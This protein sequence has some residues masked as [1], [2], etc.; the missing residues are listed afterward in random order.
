[1]PFQSTRDR[2]LIDHL[3]VHEQRELLD[4]LVVVALCIATS[5]MAPV[6]IAFVFLSPL[7]VCIAATAIAANL[8]VLDW[9]KKR[10]KRCLY[11]TSYAK[12]HAG[13]ATGE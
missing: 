1:L 9:F 4:R 8:F 5:T 13:I 7:A 10:H 2:S 6:L 12:Q 11:S 3:T